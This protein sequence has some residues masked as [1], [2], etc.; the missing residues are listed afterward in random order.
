MAARPAAAPMPHPR[1]HVGGYVDGALACVAGGREPLTNGTIACLDT[2]SLTWRPPVLMPTATSGA[3]AAVLNGLTV[4]A[5][6]EPSNETSIF[7]GVLE[8][9]AG[10]WTTQPMIT[11][12]HGTGF[13]FAP[14]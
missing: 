13:G 7:G 1:N 5:G 8:L 14:L 12:R 3:A 6:G 2:T 4:V 9:R 11:P 10:V